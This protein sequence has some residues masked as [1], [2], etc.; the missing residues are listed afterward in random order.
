[1]QRGREVLLQRPPQRRPAAPSPAPPA[2][3]D[4]GRAVLPAFARQVLLRPVRIGTLALL[5]GMTAIVLVGAEGWWIVLGIS[6]F[7][8]AASALIVMWV[9]LPARPHQHVESQRGCWFVS[10]QVPRQRRPRPDE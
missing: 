3:C 1:M 9:E 5:G 7:Q 2:W 6:L 4:W 8:A 10:D